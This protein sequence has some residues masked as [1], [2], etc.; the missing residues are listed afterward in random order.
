[1][2][3]QKSK[4]KIGI[5]GRCL[6]GNRTGVGKYLLELCRYF[7]NEFHDCEFYIYSNNEFSFPLS[8]QNWHLILDPSK[9]WRRVKKIP[10]LKFRLG[11]LSKKDDLD[12]FWGP[13]HF[14]PNLPSHVHSI[15]TVHDFF[16][17]Y[18][19]SLMSHGHRIAHQFWQKRDLFKA[20]TIVV[21]SRATGEKL[22][23]FFNIHQ[24][25]IVPPGIDPIF[26]KASSIRIKEIQKKYA[27]EE[28]FFLSVA[29][30]NPRKNLETVILAF[31]EA[32]KST[33]FKNYKL[34][35]VGEKGWNHATINKLI[36]SKFT[37]SI[38]HLGYVEEFDLPALYSAC[39]AFLF[40]S[41]YEGFGMPVLEARACGA[42]IITTDLPELREAGGDYAIYIK[43]NVTEM[44]NGFEQLDT[45]NL[46]DYSFDPNAFSWELS[47]QKMAKIILSNLM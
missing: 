19:P 46:K 13:M 7:G 15:I 34:V 38:I 31:L 9:Y 32:K 40:P 4:F 20:N 44:L 35:L 23:E 39:T 27:I 8:N 21:N 2:H 25:S 41:F 33:K 16:Y 11:F 3:T 43:P 18:T 47:S 29:T 24:Y 37:K 12:C 26:T 28:P 45:L 6:V 30:W 22:S 10:W 42:K 5:D 17:R 1:M 14:L 36:Y